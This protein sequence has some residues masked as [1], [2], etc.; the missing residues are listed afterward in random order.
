MHPIFGGGHSCSIPQG[1]I[2]DVQPFVKSLI[3]PTKQSPNGFCDFET[4]IPLKLDTTFLGEGINSLWLEGF[5]PR[6]SMIWARG[7]WIG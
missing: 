4:S 1:M 5:E 3:C 2:L 6:S 7:R